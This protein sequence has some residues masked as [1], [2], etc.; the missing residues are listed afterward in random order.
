M[1]SVIGWLKVKPGKRDELMQLA[2]SVLPLTQK[3]D[4]CLFYEFHPSTLDPDLIIVIEAWETK[5]HH[6][7]HQNA[8]HHVA[9]GKAVGPLAASGRFEEMEVAKVAT[10]RF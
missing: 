8:P 2:A 4:G 1:L 7:T 5:A 9:F 6:Q 10:Q 3:E